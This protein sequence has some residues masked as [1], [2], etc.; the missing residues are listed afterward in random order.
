[1]LLQTSLAR[2]WLGSDFHLAINAHHRAIVE[3]IEVGAPDRAE[4][5]MRDRL[6]YLRPYYERTWR[7]AER[8]V[9]RA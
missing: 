5:E 2:S 7:S 6:T 1:M 8:A 3:A 9:A 4:R